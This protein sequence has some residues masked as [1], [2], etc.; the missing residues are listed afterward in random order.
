MF[1][2]LNPYIGYSW[3]DYISCWYLIDWDASLSLSLILYVHMHW[4]EIEYMLG[5]WRW[6][7]L[8]IVRYWDYNLGTWISSMQ[9]LFNF[10]IVCL[11]R[12]H[13][14]VEIIFVGIW[15][16]RVLHG[17]WILDE[18]SRSIIYLQLIELWKT[19]HIIS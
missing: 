19:A 1:F 4:H 3:G 8:G 5:T 13:R 2:L 17:S 7:V 11:D 18:F 12:P 16:S 9:K 14:H 6:F 15:T 10:M